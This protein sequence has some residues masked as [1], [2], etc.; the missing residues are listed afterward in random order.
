MA[1]ESG[2]QTEMDHWQLGREYGEVQRLMA[3]LAEEVERRRSQNR[4][5]L[6]QADWEW[7]TA[8]QHMFK[9]DKTILRRD[10][11]LVAAEAGFNV[12]NLFAFVLEIPPGGT[13]GA[14]HMHGEAIK[15]YL[16]GRGQEIIAGHEY[17]VEAGDVLFVP[18]HTWHGT[19]NPYGDTERF[20]AIAH[21][22]QGAPIFH[23]PIFRTREDLRVP[24]FEESPIGQ[25]IARKDYGTMQ[26]FELSR[27]RQYFLEKLGDLE[28]QMEERRGQ[29][30]HLLKRSELEWGPLWPE[31]GNDPR[32]T[33]ALIAKTVCPELGFNVHNFFAAFVQ[34]PPDGA[35]VPSHAHGEEMQF[36]TQGRGR[37]F[38]GTAVYEVEPGDT[39]FIP[40]NT[41]HGVENT[42]TEPLIYFSTMQGRGNPVAHV[43]ISRVG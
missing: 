34:L 16:Q 18:A 4:H 14:Y 3:E 32:R 12:Y 13:E 5:H 25:A 42:S 39:V 43:P 38:V 31:L 30:R 37:A 11:R 28:T 36:Y 33:S 22:G 19:Q 29:D 8:K 40:A 17:E 26:P 10:A 35:G 20:V 15:L 1:I 6:K 23:Q 24:G 21:T 41:W 9:I 7:L 27:A 2:T